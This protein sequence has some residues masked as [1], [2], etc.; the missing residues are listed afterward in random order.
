MAGS[1]SVKK[2]TSITV[3][4]SNK[5]FGG[6]IY[7]FNFQMAFSQKPCEVIINVVSDGSSTSTP[8]KLDLK[9]SQ[10]IKMGSLDLGNFYPYKI[11]NASSTANGTTMEVS[12]MDP[13]FVL[14]KIWIGLIGK[15]GWSNAYANDIKNTAT[16]YYAKNKG[17]TDILGPDKDKTP[18]VNDKNNP[19]YE[20]NDSGGSNLFLIGRLFHPCDVNKD[21]QI[22][23]KEDKNVDPCDPC[24]YCPEDKYETRCFELG[25]TKI[26]ET[27]YSLK[28]LVDSWP[29]IKFPNT[30]TIGIEAPSLVLTA[31]NGDKPYEKYYRDYHGPLREVLTSWANDF[32]LFWYYDLT[33]KKIKFIDISSQTIKVDAGAVLGKYSTDT[34]V[35]YELEESLENTRKIASISWYER[36][37]ERKNFD[38]SKSQG[39]A[40]S[41]LYAA[42]LLGNRLRDNVK[43]GNGKTK[44]L[45]ANSGAIG[46]IL[47]A[48][49][50][51]LRDV[52][53]IRDVYDLTDANATASM[54]VQLNLDT[55][56][57]DDGS[58][59]Q[60]QSLYEM[61]D[62][63]V[64][65]VISNNLDEANKKKTKFQELAQYQLEN[66]K[67]QL[68]DTEQE[69][70]N[71][72]SGYFIVAYQNEDFYQRIKKLEQEMFNFGG[73][74][75]VRE[76]VGRMCG[77]TGTEEFVRH[78]TQIETADGSAGIYSKSEGIDSNPLAKYIRRDKGYL[79]CVV[80]TGNLSTPADQTK[81]MVQD[82]ASANPQNNG[83]QWQ[84]VQ[85]KD[86]GDGYILSQTYAAS[87]GSEG[88]KYYDHDQSNFSISKGST[89]PL[90]LSQSVVILERQPKWVPSVD[91]FDQ[92]RTK[93]ANS[94][95]SR[96][97]WK[98]IGSDGQAFGTPWTKA[99][100]GK[101]VNDVDA[102]KGALQSGLIESIKIF[103]A[104]PGKFEIKETKKD[105]PTDLDIYQ[106]K[107]YEVVSRRIGGR[108]NSK[109][110]VGLLSNKSSELTVKID[111]DDK[112]IPKIYTPPFFLGNSN[113]LNG[114][115]VND[116][117]KSKRNTPCDEA[118]GTENRPP[119]YKV[120]INQSFNQQ[121]ILPKIQTGYNSGIKAPEEVMNFDVSYNSISNDE[122]IAFTG[123]SGYG[124]VPSLKYLSGINSVYSTYVFDNSTPDKSLRLQIKSLPQLQS[125]SEE[126]KKGLNNINIILN[127]NGVSSDLY[128]STKACKSISRDLIKWK[129]QT[130]ISKTVKGH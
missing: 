83:M 116:I 35:S 37:G 128:Y 16:N 77:I 111:G 117:Y 19:I 46:G 69:N 22:S 96:L 121:V 20:P 94:T 104:Y 9:T 3:G 126:I 100:F 25:Q 71:K 86:Y 74:F 2:I 105:H 42:D 53:W 91:E 51:P 130:R 24:P 70:F 39:L 123:Y 14:D 79:P 28:D 88:T 36:E 92:Y 10:P 127:E 48:Y 103:Y 112:I 33:E 47:G 122:F 29:K 32:G 54:I 52:Y 106:K 95:F 90:R 80:G 1:T 59:K 113:N 12:F 57:N 7:N 5:I 26:F 6:R 124:C 65:A 72:N 34:L 60:A 27:A 50:E 76:H 119:A 129:N 120:I 58:S 108:Y 99:A 30:V 43:V 114:Q 78:N 81:G 75:Y 64:L 98:Y 125:Y 13:S 18:W 49:Y 82:Q 61:G 67:A 110:K 11:K 40:L 73:K 55:G 118:M 66:L 15:H 56:F 89:V 93:L 44:R 101:D 21:N 107:D 115:I 23:P 102:Q 17:Y 68:T 87:P 85:G 38:C 4:G 62:L 97:P 31:P 45:N 109:T 63:T 8:P 84:K 41:P